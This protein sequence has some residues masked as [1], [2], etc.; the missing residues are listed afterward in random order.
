M[1]GRS[2]RRRET[3]D[4]MHARE[5]HGFEPRRQEPT[6]WLEGDQGDGSG[7]RSCWTLGLLDDSDDP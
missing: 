3:K 5:C 2:P 1:A 4:W 7:E 6:V